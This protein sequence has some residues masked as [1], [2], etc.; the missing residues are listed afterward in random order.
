MKLLNGESRILLLGI[1]LLGA[2]GIVCLFKWNDAVGSSVVTGFVS[3]VTMCATQHYALKRYEVERGQ[4][5]PQPTE[6][7]KQ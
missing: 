6:Q 5:K 1:A 2:M 3:I 7:P 4:N